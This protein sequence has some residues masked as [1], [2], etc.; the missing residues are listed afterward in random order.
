MYSFEEI[1]VNGSIIFLAFSVLIQIDILFNLLAMD[2]F[3]Q[4]L[5]HTVFKM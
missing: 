1:C 4:I 3:F 2:F 5:A